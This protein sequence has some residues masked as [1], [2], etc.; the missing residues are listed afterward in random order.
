MSTTS[1]TSEL[2]AINFMLGTI[3][4]SPVNSLDGGSP[5][6]ALARQTLDSA[7]R[8]L[9]LRGWSWNSLP[10]IVLARSISSGE[11]SVPANTLRVDTT[12]NDAQIDVVLRGT[13]LFDR[14]NAT[15]AF[16]RGLTVE[17]V[18][19]LDW[20]DLPEPARQFIMRSACREFE[21]RQLGSDTVAR[22]AT[23]DE[24]LA[25]AALLDF[26]AETG[27]YNVLTGSRSVAGALVR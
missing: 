13:R 27:D 3:G 25:W 10:S 1:L 22:D 2:E 15:Y 17:L 19:L 6:V 20:A 7:S 26:E 16:T 9:Q 5:D 24:Q 11:I 12:G 14:V 4:E 8:S 21:A 18:Q 23:R